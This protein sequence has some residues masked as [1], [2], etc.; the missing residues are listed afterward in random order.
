[1]K[2]LL[3]SAAWFTLIGFAAEPPPDADLA[4][5][6]KKVEFKLYCRAPGYTEGPTWRN[7]ELF[8]CSGGLMRVDKAGRV[9]KYLDVS[10]AGT[11]L[12]GNGH[13]LI[14][15]NK[16][17]AILDLS[18]HGVLGVV[19]DQ[20]DGKPLR[21]LNDL[22]VDARG[23]VYWTDPERLVGEESRR[24]YLSG[25][26]R[27]ARYRASPRDWPF[28]TASRS[29]RR[30]SSCMSSNRRSKKILRY[31]LP[32]DDKPLGKAE[33]FFDLGGSG[34]DG[35]VFDA[36]GNFWVADFHRP[37]TKRGPHHGAVAAGQGAG[38]R[39]GAGQGGQQHHLRRPRP[40]RDLLHHRHSRRRLPG[41]GRCQGI[42][43]S[44]GKRNQ[45]RPRDSH[46]ARGSGI[47]R[48]S[49]PLRVARRHRRHARLVHLA[50]IQPGYL[51][52]GG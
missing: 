20:Y 19:A 10:P 14:C 22:T 33:V 37:E 11:V 24:Q 32:A 44:S 18:P 4:Q 23:N 47:G 5:R 21:S 50:K 9:E 25:D 36:A 42:C 39:G 7:G 34:G 28:P 41:Q 45:N 38:Q 8:F 51:A 27:R 46:P 48:P 12:R 6:L 17:K 49:A 13:L 30:A 3:L 31:P 43:R 52:G 15:D 35:C 1:M 26:A 29:I 16:H 2:R 40:R